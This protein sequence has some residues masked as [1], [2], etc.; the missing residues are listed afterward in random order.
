[1][2]STKMNAPFVFAG[3]LLF[4]VGRLVPL[5][6]ITEGS[7][8]PGDDDFGRFCWAVLARVLR[9]EGTTGFT[10]ST[11]TTSSGKPTVKASTFLF[12]NDLTEE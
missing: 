4:I 3:A 6:L 10:S 12:N 5:D 9:G 8:G 7:S 1:M 2:S 11:I